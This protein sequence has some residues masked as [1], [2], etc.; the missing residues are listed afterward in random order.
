M[1]ASP[2]ASSDRFFHNEVQEVPAFLPLTADLDVEGGVDA[3]AG[4]QKISR[5]E[6]RKGVGGVGDLNEQHALPSQ[7]DHLGVSLFLRSPLLR[8]TCDPRTGSGKASAGRPVH[9]QL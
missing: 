9:L 1:I 7:E 4:T 6:G 2:F 5:R 3:G 8:G